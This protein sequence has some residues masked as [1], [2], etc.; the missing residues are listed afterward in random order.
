MRIEKILIAL[1]LL[2]IILKLAG[3][4]GA[5]ILLVIIASAVSL[6]Y[7]SFGHYT[8]E[9]GSF[10]RHRSR[11][12][13]GA[14]LALSI[15]PLAAVFKLQNWGGASAMLAAALVLL[16]PMVIITYRNYKNDKDQRRQYYR[17]MLIR[18]IACLALCLILLLLPD[19]DQSTGAVV[20]VN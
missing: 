1:F 10:R 5:G 14:A 9:N 18:L 12:A 16:T 11:F 17:Q 8:Y 19:A 3:V 13:T 2:A 6:L 4:T 20:Q 7:F 15:V